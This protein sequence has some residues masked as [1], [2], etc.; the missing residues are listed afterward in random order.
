M[1]K[2]FSL[3]SVARSFSSE[4]S[5]A[6]SFFSYNDRLMALMGPTSTLYSR[7]RLR[8][9][10]TSNRETLERSCAAF[11]AGT[12]VSGVDGSS[13]SGRRF[14]RIDAARGVELNEP[15]ERLLS[16]VRRIGVDVDGPGT[17]RSRSESACEGSRGDGSGSSFSSS[18]SP[19]ASSSDSGVARP[20]GPDPLE[21]CEF[22][23]VEY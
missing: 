9:V 6:T 21:L 11:S 17:E 16:G 10:A 19:T 8:R 5:M 13:R 2:K 12:G 15:S 14:R 7:K 23:C 22:G 3:L 20:V 4:T 1:Q 18:A